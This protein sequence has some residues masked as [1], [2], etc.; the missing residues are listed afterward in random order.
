MVQDEGIALLT[1]A[2]VSHI[3]QALVAVSSARDVGGFDEIYLF[4]VDARSAAT[5]VIR[6]SLGADFAWLNLICIDD[7]SA[8]LSEKLLQCY[9][10]FDPFEICC[11]AKYI[12]IAHILSSGSRS[13]YCVFADADILF[14]GSVDSLKTE[15]SDHALMLTPHQFSPSTGFAEHEYLH[16]GWINAGFFAVNR[17]HSGLGDILTWLID[18]ISK[19]GFVA[20]PIGLF[21]DQKWVSL[22]PSLFGNDVKISSHPGL[23]IAYWNL[24]ERHIWLNGRTP[25]V[26]SEALI[27]FHFSGFVGA[28]LGKL[29]KHADIDV[30]ENS[31]LAG[32]C[33]SYSHQLANCSHIEIPKVSTQPFSGKRLKDRIEVC[34]H[35]YGLA[36]NPSFHVAGLFGWL[37]R[38]LDILIDRVVRKRR[39]K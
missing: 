39:T 32:L 17:H 38:N 6:E 19:Y 5:Q 3:T 9:S 30:E 11:L 31:P 34:S 28:K 16:Y 18:R 35:I 8:D 7:L 25:M 20:L 10:Y 23:N 33:K 22:C 12:G 36:L 15:L 13:R 37:G 24:N 14:T 26:N 27:F 1:V 2:T 21:C 29:S 4:V